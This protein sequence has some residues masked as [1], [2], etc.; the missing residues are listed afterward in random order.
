M[1]LTNITSISDMGYQTSKKIKKT[2]VGKIKNKKDGTST[3]LE[4]SSNQQEKIKS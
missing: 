1:G 4:N 3:N 2:L